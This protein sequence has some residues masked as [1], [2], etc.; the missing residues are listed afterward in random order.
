[1]LE[2]IFEN[3]FAPKIQWKLK[4]IIREAKPPVNVKKV[5]IF[6][7]ALENLAKHSY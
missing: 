7:L 2:V 4:K 5:G 3:G 6:T 1:M